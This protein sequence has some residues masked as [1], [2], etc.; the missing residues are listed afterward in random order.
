MGLVW[1]REALERYEPRRLRASHLPHIRA[2]LGIT[3]FSA[4]GRRV[5]VGALLEAAQSKALLAD[6]INVGI[7]AL[8]KARDALPA[9]R[10]LKR[11][12]QAARAQVNQGDDHQVY[13]A[14]DDRQ[15]QAITA[16]LTRDAHETTSPWQRLQR[17]PRHPTTKRI[18]E[19]L[20]PP[21]W[22]QSLNTARHA[23]DAIPETTFQ[24]CADEARALQVTQMNRYRD[25][26]RATL[27]VALTRVHTA[28]ALDD[29]AEMFL[30]L[31]Q[32]M[33]HKAQAA[34]DAS[35][36]AHPEP[37]EAL[38]SLLSERVGGWQQSET[39]EEQLKTIRTVI[40][41]DTD[42]ILEQCAAHLAYAGHNSWPFLLPRLRPHRTRFFE[43]LEFLQPRSTSTA[44]A[45][46]HAMAFVLRHRHA[47]VARLSI[48]ADGPEAQA[49]LA[50]SWMPPRWW[51]AVTG[52]HRRD[53]P[54][55][56]VAR[57]SLE[58]CVLSCAMTDR[59]SCDLSMEGSE[60]CSD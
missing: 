17:E 18:R 54:V 38:L 9:F 39:T 29:L 55:V 15:R 19:P 46:E 41:A 22:L 12:A 6:L 42:N 36:R 2:H 56:T 26:Q 24:R 21:R 59:K 51:Q 33:H 16:L 8:G 37:T 28:Q 32:K 52:R 49:L 35:R 58:L 47:Q 10:R 45:L 27:A 11:A 23:V 31:R 14:L 1:P 48:I 4:G 3:A 30:R 40:G 50:S 57:Q 7:E 20:A 43:I 53:V 44:K 25:A 34:L 60:Q 5:R 13:H